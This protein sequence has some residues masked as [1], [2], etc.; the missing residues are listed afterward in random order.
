MCG[1]PFSCVAVLE[2]VNRMFSRGASD[3]SPP[4]RVYSPIHPNIL[5]WARDAL[6]LTKD[7]D[8][9]QSIARRRDAEARLEGVPDSRR[10]RWDA[11]WS[12][13]TQLL[14]EDQATNSQ[15]WRTIPGMLDVAGGPVAP[16]L[17]WN[18][19]ERLIAAALPT[20][21]GIVSPSAMSWWRDIQNQAQRWGS[22]GM[23][24][25]ELLKAVRSRND[26][27]AVVLYVLLSDRPALVPISRGVYYVSNASFG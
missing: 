25:P 13:V 2:S 16:E 1:P 19:Y 26:S 7:S 8:P 24:N 17:R 9:W 5:L 27:G 10:D 18:D 23:S 14:S 3:Q 6:D 21:W 15:S 12:S 11:A 4:I 20:E 22:N